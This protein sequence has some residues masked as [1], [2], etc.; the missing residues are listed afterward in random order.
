MKIEVK[1]S[2]IDKGVKVHSC[3]CPVALAIKDALDAPDNS[4]SVGTW[5]INIKLNM[6]NETIE[7]DFNSKVS[8]FISQFDRGVNVKPMSFHLAV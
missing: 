8:Q 7:I 1:Q 3:L 2:H 4:V 6:F 5:G